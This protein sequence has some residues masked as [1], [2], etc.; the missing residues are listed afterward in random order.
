[1]RLVDGKP[2]VEWHPSARLE[3]FMANQMSTGNHWC[4]L[5]GS[6]QTKGQLAAKPRVDQLQWARYDLLMPRQ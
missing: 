4:D 6:W 1:M 3:W 2:K 5:T